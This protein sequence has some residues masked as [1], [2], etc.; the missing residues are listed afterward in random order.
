MTNLLLFVDLMTRLNMP[1]VIVGIVLSV[2]GISVA[3]LAKRI[4]RCFRKD[5]VVSDDDKLLIV[6]KSIG[7][8]LVIAGLICTIVK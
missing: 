6:L 1:N 5:G 2:V 7:L 4:T 3:L 8:I